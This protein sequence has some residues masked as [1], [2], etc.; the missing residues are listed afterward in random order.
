MNEGKQPAE[1]SLQ[2]RLRILNIL[3]EAGRGGMPLKAKEITSMCVDSGFP[4]TTRTVQ[5]DLAAMY[6]S[7]SVW[8]ALGVELE[9]QQGASVQEKK[10]RHAPGSKLNFM[11]R[12]SSVQALTLVLIDQEFQPFLPQSAYQDLCPDFQS[13][14]RILGQADMRY[15]RYR[16]RV[17]VLPEGPPRAMPAAIVEV[18]RQISEALLR[19]EQVNVRY[20]SSKGGPDEQDYRLHPLGLVQQGLFH[21][22]LAVKDEHVFH[23]RLLE[24]VRSYRCDRIRQITPRRSETVAKG[25]PTLDEALAAGRLEFFAQEEPVALVLRFAATEQG[26]ALCTSFREAPLGSGQVISRN[27]Q[28]G[29]D[30]RTQVRHSLQLEWLLQRYADRIKVLQPAALAEHLG[31]FAQAAAAMQSGK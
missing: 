18:L 19:S 6:E 31:K 5:R 30:L 4:C 29:Y 16:E 17:R 15:A 13:A 25:L 1:S 28:G 12:L 3:P 14:H 22:L 7:T 26:D 23:P 8:R 20:V 24:K 2:R 21:W 11:N 9:Y 10:W 27:E